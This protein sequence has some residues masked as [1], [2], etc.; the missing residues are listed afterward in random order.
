[1]ASL[2]SL[3]L[4]FAIPSVVTLRPFYC[5]YHRHDCPARKVY[6]TPSYNAER[7]MHMYLYWWAE[8]G[9]GTMEGKMLRSTAEIHI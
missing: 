2:T 9:G 6:L 4:P 8:N 5:R 3:V 1:M 7:L